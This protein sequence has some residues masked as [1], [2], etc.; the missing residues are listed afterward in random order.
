M[1]IGYVT[2]AGVETRCYMAG[3][4]G[5]PLLLIHGIGSSS[6]SWLR[7]LEPLARRFRV[8][9]PDLLGHGFTGLGDYRGGPPQPAMVAHL[10]AV[11]DSMGFGRFAVMGSSYG[12]LLALLCRFAAPDS[13]EKVVMLS[14]ASS[15]MPEAQRMGSFVAARNAALATMDNPSLDFARRRMAGMVFD[16]ACAPPELLLLQM[17]VFARPGLRAGFETI[18]AGLMDLEAGRPFSVAERFA[19][20]TC[21]LLMIW[22]AQDPHAKLDQARAAARA[23]RD[24]RFLALERCGHVPHVEHPAVVADLVG[25]FL[26]GEAMEE[27]RPG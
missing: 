9:A 4:S 11:A 20:V 2:A 7:V 14:S 19:E 3:E 12:A 10:L 22:G 5:P 17:N 24:A 16:P 23:A 6:D 25:R 1:R 27:L 26:D 21:P 13:V 18:I 8:V 15:T